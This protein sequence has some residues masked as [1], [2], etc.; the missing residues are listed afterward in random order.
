MP[1]GPVLEDGTATVCF[2]EMTGHT[3]QLAVIRPLNL[4]WFVSLGGLLP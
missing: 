4:L 2:E 1:I 3:G